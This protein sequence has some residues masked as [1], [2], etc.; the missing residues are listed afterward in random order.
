MSENPD[1]GIFQYDG[2]LRYIVNGYLVDLELGPKGVCGCLRFETHV[3][4]M[5]RLGSPMVTCKHIRA[6]RDFLRN[7]ILRGDFDRCLINET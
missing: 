2:P 7:R 3:A 4:K 6:A 1:I 5:I